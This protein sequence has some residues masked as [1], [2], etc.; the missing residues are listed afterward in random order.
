VGEV[1]RLL[2]VFVAAVVAASLVAATSVAAAGVAT[3]VHFSATFPFPFTDTDTCGFPIDVNLQVD[4]HGTVFL[5]AQGNFQSAIVE[6]NIVGTDTANGVTVRD[7]THYVDFM[8]SLGG[9][10]GV[11][12]DFHVQNGGL[13]LRNAGYLA[14]N[15]DGS[16][17]FVHGPHPFPTGD[18]SA[19]CEAF[20]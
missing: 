7:A 19:F 13:I 8:D 17:A 20:S 10:K 1:T 3:P 16:V 2:F 11:G 4:L 15:P 9:V 6:Q 18:I 14:I 12:L 5:D